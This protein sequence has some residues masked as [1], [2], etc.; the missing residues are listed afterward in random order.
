MLALVP[1]RGRDDLIDQVFAPA[2]QALW[3]A[4]AMHDP[5]AELYYAEPHFTACLDTAFAVVEP[6]RPDIA[7]GRAFAVAFAW[8]GVKGRE[9]LPDTGW[10]GVIR[11]GAEDRALGRTPDALSALEITLLHSHRGRGGS[12]VVLDAMR[13]RA[14]ELGLRHMVAPVRPTGKAAEPL[15]PMRDYAMRVRADGLPADPWLRVHVRAG[16]RIEKLAPL[17]MTF[18]GTLADWRAWTG[19]PFDA[20]GPV[21]VPDALVPVHCSVEHDHAVYVEP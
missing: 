8:D 11:W 18:P 7:V 16:G 21:I 10:D 9:A 19:L 3:P 20:S 4:Y 17:S 15:T 6:D 5:T 13:R 12:A 14:A 1:L 2:I